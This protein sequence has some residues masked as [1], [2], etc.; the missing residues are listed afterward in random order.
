MHSLQTIQ[1]HQDKARSSGEKTRKIK[2]SIKIQGPQIISTFEII[3]LILY[4]VIGSN[5]HGYKFLCLLFIE[6]GLFK[7]VDFL[8][9]GYQ[10]FAILLAS[11]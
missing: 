5:L 4:P 11:S 10:V 1:V 6:M 3:L 7:I 9:E 8:F 2:E